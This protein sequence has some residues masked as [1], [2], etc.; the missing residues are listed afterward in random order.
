MNLASLLYLCP[1]L[2]IISDPPGVW[3]LQ[4]YLTLRE[5]DVTFHL[6]NAPSVISAVITWVLFIEDLAVLIRHS[7]ASANT[8]RTIQA[9]MLSGKHNW[10]IPT[11]SLSTACCLSHTYT[12]YKKQNKRKQYGYVGEYYFT[13]RVVFWAMQILVTPPITRWSK[14]LAV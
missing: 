2:I 4:K 10:I 8:G 5:T 6:N 1:S 11:E 3:N 13:P 9:R 12:G 7:G 14:F